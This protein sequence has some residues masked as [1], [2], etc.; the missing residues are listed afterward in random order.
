MMLDLLSSIQS[1]TNVNVLLVLPVL[2]LQYLTLQFMKSNA[3]V[4]GLSH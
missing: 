2:K 4:I 1:Q 3:H